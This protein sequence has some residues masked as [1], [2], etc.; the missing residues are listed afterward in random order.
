[1]A[2][3]FSG[4]AVSGVGFGRLERVKDLVPVK[5]W[6]YSTGGVTNKNTILLIQ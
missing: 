4:M 2:S 5:A 3:T 6:G 1:M